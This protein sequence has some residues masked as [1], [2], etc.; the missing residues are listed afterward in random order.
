PASSRRTRCSR[1]TAVTMADAEL[2]VYGATAAGVCA[3]VA[4]A[5]HGVQVTVIEPG[6]HVGGMVSGGLGYTDLGDPAVVGGLAREFAVAV[7]EN[8]GVPPGHY[9]GPEPHAAEEIFAGWLDRAGVDVVFD[10]TIT[11]VSTVD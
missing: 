9:A 7:G 6:R 11:V 5:R 1:W 2:I 8:Y 10:T 3:A 4:A